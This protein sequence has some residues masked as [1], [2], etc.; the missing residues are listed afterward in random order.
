MS[1]IPP[2]GPSAKKRSGEHLIQALVARLRGPT[3]REHLDSMFPDE[4]ACRTYLAA[5]RWPDG[6]ECPHCGSREGADASARGLLRCPHCAVVCSPTVHTLLETSPLPLR[7]WFQ[8]IWGVVGREQGASPLAVGQLL[9][10]GDLVWGWLANLR[11]IYRQSWR[12][13]LCGVVEV[14]R[15]PVDVALGPSRDR[16]HM[17]HTVVVVA[18]EVKGSDG[19]RVRIQRL[20]QV[21][22]ASME[23]FVSRA[24]ARGSTVR[25]S[26]WR[27]YGRLRA[28]GYGHLRSLA[29]DGNDEAEMR[30]AQQIASVLRLWLWTSDA[31]ELERLD[32]YLEEF[33]F[34]LNVRFR[35]PKSHPGSLFNEI[36]RLACSPSR[37]AGFKR[38]TIESA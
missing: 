33:A 7:T 3:S 2:P 24:V 34:R 37:H 28:L 8:A 6:F 30:H 35:W 15:V 10:R 13:Q 26:A 11:A 31:L 21:D 16:R 19:G 5:L 12:E 20:G 1:S 9:P 32:Y 27:G 17:G 38:R 29:P 36:L 18:V 22:A 25:T 14:A 4:A 23:G